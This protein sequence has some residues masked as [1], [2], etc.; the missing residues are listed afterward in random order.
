MNNKK[1][2][3]LLELLVVIALIGLL[4]SLIIASLV[5]VRAKTKDSKRIQDLDNIANALERFAIDYGRYPLP[6]EID[7]DGY[8]FDY[9][10]D[11]N[12]LDILVPDYLTLRPKDP[13]N[14][15]GYSP[16]EPGNN[17]YA[18]GASPSG[19]Y[20][21]LMVQLETSN[22]PKSAQYVC[23][24]WTGGWPQVED[25]YPF[26]AFVYPGCCSLGLCTMHE[27]TANTYIINSIYP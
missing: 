14:N 25:Y 27:G 7:I 26:G 3:T 16:W 24:R 22:H 19:R 12:F 21:M 15:N 2:F 5:S 1:G 8:N 18:Y 23:N 17:F 4:S 20:Y 10:N 9:S 6:S 13:I 11:D